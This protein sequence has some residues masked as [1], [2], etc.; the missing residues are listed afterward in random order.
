MNEIT[1]T[2]TLKEAGDALILLSKAD[3][4]GAFTGPL[5]RRIDAAARD[6]VAKTGSA[7]KPSSPAPSVN[8]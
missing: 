1:V 6:A 4:L 8:K 2:M 3:P 5:L 7:S